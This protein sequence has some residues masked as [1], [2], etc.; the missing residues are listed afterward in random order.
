MGR[1][2]YRKIETAQFRK[3]GVYT[4]VETDAVPE[5]IVPVD[6]KWVY[7]IKRNSDG[8]IEIFQAR[9]VGRRFTQQFGTDCDE[10]Y[11]DDLVGIAPNDS[12]LDAVEEVV[13]KHVE[14]EKRGWPA[15]LLGMEC[16]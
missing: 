7:L 4:E 1:S 2:P 14:L 16:H 5:G 11:G 13:G 9:Q 3:Y 8:S 12:D 6:T 10:T 15:K